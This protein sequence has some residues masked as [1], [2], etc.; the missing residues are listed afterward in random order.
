LNTPFYAGNHP[1]CHFVDLNQDGVND[2]LFASKLASSDLESDTLYGFVTHSKLL[3]AFRIPPWRILTFQPGASLLLGPNGD[4]KMNREYDEYLPPWDIVNFFSTNLS[5]GKAI[6]IV[7]SGMGQAPDQIAVLDG[8][9]KKLG[10]YWHA[11][12]LGYGQFASYNG[13]ERI[14]LGGVNNGYHS[15]TLIAFDPN[16]I[17]G[18]TDLSVDLPDRALKFGLLKVGTREHLEPLGPGTE[19]CR[20]IFTRTCIAKAKLHIEPY[21]RLVGLTVTDSRIFAT[22]AESEK[23]ESR[24]RVVYEMD[25]HLNLVEAAPTTEFRQRHSELERAGLLDHVFSAE[26]LKPL[27]HVLPGCEFVEKRK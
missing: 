11:G 2:V 5:N 6:L 20:V 15:A 13:Q 21:N 8:G 19:T 9:L 27:I 25:R 22:I 26:E 14:F 10:E 4:P 16:K 18:T 24:V 23:G 1:L 12:V 17:A 7:S 3:R